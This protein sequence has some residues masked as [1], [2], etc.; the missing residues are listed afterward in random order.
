[1]EDEAD[2]A[3]HGFRQRA[4]V[5]ALVVGDDEDVARLREVAVQRPQ[6][7]VDLLEGL[8]AAPSRLGNCSRSSPNRAA[9]VLKSS[10]FR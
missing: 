4:Q 8:V 10:D 1:V 6:R 3:L 2:L 9:A 7:Q 5:E